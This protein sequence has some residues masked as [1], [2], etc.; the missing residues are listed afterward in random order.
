MVEAF[1]GQRVAV[2]QM[3]E[4]Q[5]GCRVVRFLRIR[6]NCLTLDDL[7]R[8]AQRDGKAVGIGDPFKVKARS[9]QPG[10]WCRS[11]SS[12]GSGAVVGMAG[13][14]ITVPWTCANGVNV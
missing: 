5:V 3:G 10:K 11:S 6:E 8:C 9:F 14:V 4:R 13:Y 1:Y 12:L 7:R 2:R